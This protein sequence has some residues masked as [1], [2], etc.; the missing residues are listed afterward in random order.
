MP[1]IFID[2]NM[3]FL[4]MAGQSLKIILHSY[5]LKIKILKLIIHIW[6]TNMKKQKTTFKN[7][8]SKNKREEGVDKAKTKQ[9]VVKVALK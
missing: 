8:P 7:T 2:N 4:T 9:K 3:R 5:V 1:I 6:P